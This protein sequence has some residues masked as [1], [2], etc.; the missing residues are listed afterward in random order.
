MVAM[1]KFNYT[2]VGNVTT[3]SVTNFGSK[4]PGHIE[5]DIFSY[6]LITGFLLFTPIYNMCRVVYSGRRKIYPENMTL[7]RLCYIPS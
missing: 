3:K 6:Y 4:T 2:L 1:T 5:F 7:Q